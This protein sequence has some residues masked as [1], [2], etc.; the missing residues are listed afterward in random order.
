MIERALR[1]HCFSYMAI[2]LHERN[3]F[4]ECKN[5]KIEIQD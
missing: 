4:E 3:W 2:Q 5:V 1:G